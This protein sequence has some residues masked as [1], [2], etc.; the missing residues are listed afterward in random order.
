M[1]SKIYRFIGRTILIFVY[2]DHFPLGNKRDV[3]VFIAFICGLA[4]LD[5]GIRED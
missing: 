4:F 2:L 5:A 3:I 1:L